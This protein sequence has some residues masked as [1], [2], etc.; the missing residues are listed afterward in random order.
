M[1][2][3]SINTVQ[4]KAFYVRTEVEDKEERWNDSYSTQDGYY[5]IHEGK[6]HHIY[7]VR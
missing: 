3:D 4:G 7:Q 1:H 2:E 5:V 6:E